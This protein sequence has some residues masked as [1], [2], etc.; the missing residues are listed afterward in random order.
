MRRPCVVIHRPGFAGQPLHDLRASRI[1]FQPLRTL[2]ADEAQAECRPVRRR[3]SAIARLSVPL[4][5]ALLDATALSFGVVELAPHVV[6]IG[7]PREVDRPVIFMLKLPQLDAHIAQLAELLSTEELVAREAVERVD[8][9]RIN[10]QR[11]KLLEHA[12]E[13]LALEHGAGT[14][15]LGICLN[16]DCAC[17]LKENAEACLLVVKR[18]AAVALCFRGQACVGHDAYRSLLLVTV[19]TWAPGLFEGRARQAS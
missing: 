18:H 13:R 12:E 8:H 16:A 19:G 4:Q 11:R 2:G 6:T 14:L 3:G 10:A 15:G 1:G 5:L 17:A 9:Q 7:V